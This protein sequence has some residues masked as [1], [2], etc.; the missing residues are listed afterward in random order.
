MGFDPIQTIKYI[1]KGIFTHIY[2]E[3]AKLITRLSLQH[4]KCHFFIKKKNNNNA[5]FL[6]FV[7]SCIK[8]FLLK[9][10]GKEKCQKLNLSRKSIDYGQSYA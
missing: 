4:K 9:I 5:N 10:S 2:I 3:N 8:Y 1:G 6:L 7:R